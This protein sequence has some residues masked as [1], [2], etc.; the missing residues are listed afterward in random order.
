MTEIFYKTERCTLLKPTLSP[1]LYF[2][3]DI[4]TNTHTRLLIWHPLVSLCLENKSFLFVSPHTLYFFPNLAVC[5]FRGVMLFTH[6]CVSLIGESL[7]NS[8]GLNLNNRLQGRRG[9]VRRGGAFLQWWHHRP[10]LYV[11]LQNQQ[12]MWKKGEICVCKATS[13][14]VVT[15]VQNLFRLS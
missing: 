4:Y 11:A 12:P 10:V 9:V 7:F 5:F 14:S 3:W 6:F 8:K 15:I 1:F 13:L 2:S